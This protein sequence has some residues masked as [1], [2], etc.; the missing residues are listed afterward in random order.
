MK[1]KI[2]ST[3]MQDKPFPRIMVHKDKTVVM[4]SSERQGVAV[5]RDSRDGEL[6]GKE[7]EWVPCTNERIWQPFSG[8]IEFSN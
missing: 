7:E 5:M 3:N 8:T 1:S 4:F 2:V 6:T